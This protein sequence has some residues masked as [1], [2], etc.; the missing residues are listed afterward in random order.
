M[1]CISFMVSVPVL[2]VQISFALPMVSEDF[3]ERTRLF[4]SYILLTEKA[5]PMVTARGRPS[6][7]ATTTI[8]MPKMKA[9]KT[10]AMF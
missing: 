10:S 2:S 3:I 9:F 6:G 8:V 4:S 5:R 1:T 7:M